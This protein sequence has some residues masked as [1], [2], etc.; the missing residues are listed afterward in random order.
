MAKVELTPNQQKILRLMRQ[1]RKIEQTDTGR[2]Y[3]CGDGKLEHLGYDDISVLQRAGYVTDGFRLTKAA[4]AM[5]VTGD[6]S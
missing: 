3:L 4:K 5:E 2:V 1:G 6:E